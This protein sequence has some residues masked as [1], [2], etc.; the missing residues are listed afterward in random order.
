MNKIED[1]IIKL[2]T[3]F[4]KLIDFTSDKFTDLSFLWRIDGHIYISMIESTD[5]SKGY[6]TKLF[7]AIQ[8]EGYGI[9]VPTP[10]PLMEAI[11][12]KKGFQ[13]TIEHSERWGNVEVWVKD[14]K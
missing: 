6:L 1:G 3:N 10:F 5:K 2:D 13:K 12:I 9:K 7:D 4:V 14:K 11:L 8:R